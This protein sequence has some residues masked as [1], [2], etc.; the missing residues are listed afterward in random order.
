MSEKVRTEYKT[1]VEG[2]YKVS[3]QKTK[4]LKLLE[5]ET[6]IRPGNHV[7]FSPNAHKTVFI[8]VRTA[9]EVLA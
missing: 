7:A 4:R 6:V 8:T 1:K 5:G 3:V 2:L 9:D